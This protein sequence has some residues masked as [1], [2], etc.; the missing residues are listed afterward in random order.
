MVS[1]YLDV[2]EINALTMKMQDWINELDTLQE[3]IF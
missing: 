1:A 3:K 2:A